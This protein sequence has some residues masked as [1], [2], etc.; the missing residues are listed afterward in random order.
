MARAPEVSEEV[1]PEDVEAQVGWIPHLADV[2][3]TDVNCDGETQALMQHLRAVK[4]A[5]DN[6]SID[7]PWEVDTGLL[8]IVSDAYVLLVSWVWIA[9]K[10]TVLFLPLC[11]ALLPAMLLLR[12][13]AACLPTPLVKVRRGRAFR[14]LVAAEILAG[15]PFLTLASLSLV[16][17]T[18][19]YYACFVPFCLATCGHQRF[20]ES[21]K[22]IAPYRGGPPLLSHMSD[23]IVASLGQVLRHG[24]PALLR[25]VALMV[26]INPVL[27]Y[28]VHTNPLVYR[29]E[30][31]FLTQMSDAWRD[32]PVEEVLGHLCRL[33]CD[34]HVGKQDLRDRLAPLGFLPHWPHPPEGRRWALGLQVSGVSAQLLHATHAAEGGHFVLSNS[35]L[36]PAFRTPL[37]YNNPYHIFTGYAEAQI[38]TGMPSQFDKFRGGEHAM[39]VLSG[40]SPLLARRTSL[41]GVGCIE[42]CAEQW[43]PRLTYELRRLIRG[44]AIADI[45]RREAARVVRR[46]EPRKAVG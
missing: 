43:L 27:K 7:Q 29:L 40:H 39:W 38:T 9:A 32:M 44:Q 15:L 33:V 31:R 3:A 18:A 23:L 17:D 34:T 42:R 24:L 36:V 2:Q 21:V 22:A 25:K 10:T 16:L 19:V 41:F 35:C 1:G 26:L 30:E 8:A 14:L 45:V 28:F 11:L 6:T 37:W 12:L 20:V 46:P 13:H 5:D 4:A